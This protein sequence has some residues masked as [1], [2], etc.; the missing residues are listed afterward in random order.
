MA[1]S[2]NLFYR[3]RISMRCRAAAGR[4]EDIPGSGAAFPRHGSRP[5]K[6]I[7]LVSGEA[8]SL[9]AYR[10]P[11]NVR[12]ERGVRAVV[13]ADGDSVGVSEFHS[14]AQLA[15]ANG[16]SHDAP[17]LAA[18][19]VPCPDV[20]MIEIRPGPA[21]DL[22]GFAISTPT[23]TLALLWSGR[24]PSLGGRAEVMRAISLSRADVG[25]R[26]QFADRALDPLPEAKGVSTSRRSGLR[27]P[28]PF[29]RPAKVS[30]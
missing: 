24:S 17:A 19:G 15:G 27:Y 4:P 30:R 20:A 25:G 13:L 26:R 3:L 1:A 16:Q 11:G 22:W 7:R 18:G 29:E 10:W 2:A 5:G 8:L 23:G 6:R 21:P 12:R 28:L 14:V 9:L